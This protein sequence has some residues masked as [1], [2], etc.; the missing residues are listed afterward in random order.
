MV[1]LLSVVLVELIVLLTVF[2]LMRRPWEGIE[3]EVEK[4]LELEQNKLFD[5]SISAYE[6]NSSP[7]PN[8]DTSN[9]SE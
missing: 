4:V 8:E 7:L 1:Y 9:V 2:E 5:N 3:L 6:L